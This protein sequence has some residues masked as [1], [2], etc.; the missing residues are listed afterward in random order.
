M[1]SLLVMV[2]MG[3]RVRSKTPKSMLFT[4][5]C[6]QRTHRSD[7]SDALSLGIIHS[8]DTVSAKSF[9]HFTASLP[10]GVAVI[11]CPQTSPNPFP[12]TELSITSLHG[13]IKETLGN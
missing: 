11:S 1:V 8:T 7:F 6:L 3:F 5:Q 2:E 13:S 10:Y 12:P 9:W 4:P